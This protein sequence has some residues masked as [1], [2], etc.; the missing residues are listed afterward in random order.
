MARIECTAR[1]YL[2]A[3][4]LNGHQQPF[5]T[6]MAATVGEAAHAA[7]V[8]ETASAIFRQLGLGPRGELVLRGGAAGALRSTGLYGRP[9]VARRAGAAEAPIEY[10]SSVATTLPPS[11][12]FYYKAVAVVEGEDGGGAR[13][14][15]I[16]DGMTQYRIGTD[17]YQP[18]DDEDHGETCGGF[19]CYTTPEEV[20]NAI[21]PSSSVLKNAERAIIKCAGWGRRRRFPNGKVCLENMRPLSIHAFP[22]DFID[23][24]P[25]AMR[26]VAVPGA[27][28]AASRTGG[29]VPRAPGG[30][31]ATRRLAVE[32]FALEEEVRQME[33]RL[34]AARAMRGWSGAA[35]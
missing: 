20:F 23:S 6:L 5:Q 34:E 3:A 21:V 11:A 16:Y 31:P 10:S 24:A 26:G 28:D 8:E 30:G 33:A 18:M 2:L 29:I 17:L 9:R 4:T 35:A 27:R 7:R 32:N 14:L 22:R 13:F 19:F 15:S 25:V 1:R 12:R